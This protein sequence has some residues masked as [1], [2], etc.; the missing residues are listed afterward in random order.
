MRQK[1]FFFPTNENKCQEKTTG[2]QGKEEGE[3]MERRQE[4]EEEGGVER[5]KRMA[6]L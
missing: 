2:T 5:M 6:F 1:Y 4:D 3:R